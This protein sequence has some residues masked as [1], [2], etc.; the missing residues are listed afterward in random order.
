PVELTE[1]CLERIQRLGGRLNAFETVTSELA[2][3]QAH[4]ADDDARRGHFH[5]PLHGVPY[6]AKDLLATAGIR[7]TWGARP[8]PDQHFDTDATVVQRLRERRSPLLGKCAMVEFAGGLGY[9]SAAASVSG[10]G[11]NPWDPERWTGGSSSGSGAA[12]AA[13]LAPFALGTETWG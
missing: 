6:G 5:G 3:A 8:L 12:V 13:S 11:R 4:D 9:R 10:P 2:L 1:A 7:T